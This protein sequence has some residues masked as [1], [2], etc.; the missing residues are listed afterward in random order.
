[1]PPER[2]RIVE[3]L[4][5]LVGARGYE[6]TTVEAVLE[7]AE[8]GREDFD[9]H[10]A[11]K[12]DCFLAAYDE[13]A[14]EFGRR[15]LSAYFAEEEWHECMWAGGAEAM[16]FL[17]EDG[18]RARF[19]VVEVVHAGRQAQTRRDMILHQF[20]ELVDAGRDQLKDP[21]SVSRGTAEI[22]AGAV[23]GTVLT[24]IKRG[25]PSWG[26]DF[27]PELMYMAVLPYLGARAA[28]EEMRVQPLR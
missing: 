22:V 21:K 19:F 20:A 15:V 8:A 17:A 25:W 26:R 16:R 14:A 3:A 12:E 10:F 9:R 28:E 4:V 5:H 6:A 23:Y 18:E 11:G 27:L 24:K 1:V 2:D 13:V 7:R